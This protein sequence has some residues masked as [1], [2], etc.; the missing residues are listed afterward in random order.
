M[1]DELDPRPTPG[2]EVRRRLT[3]LFT[4][5]SDSTRLSGV[6]EAETYADMLDDVRQAFT[7]AVTARGGTINQFQGDGLQAL[8]GYPHINEHASRRATEAA[9]DIH[10]RVRALRRKYADQGASELS[11]HS[12]IHSGLMLA[13]QGDDV[14][15]RVELFGPAPGIAKHLSDEACSDEILVSED[16]LGPGHFLFQTGERREV[17]LKGREGSLGVYRV[18]ARGSLRTRFEAHA[19]RGLLPFIGRAAPLKMLQAALDDVTTGIPRFVAI[20]GAPGVGKT[21][22]AEE[23]LQ[24]ATESGCTVLRGW[25]EGELSAQPLQ[26]FLQMLRTLFQVPPGAV[27]AAQAVEQ[28][29]ARIDPLLQ[30]H[31]AELLAALSIATEAQDA[32]P[33]GAVTRRP[34]PEQTVL[35]LR[36]L[37][38]SLARSGPLVLFIDDW[39]WA[40]GATRQVVYAV[41]D[42]TQAPILLLAATR[43]LDPGDAQPDAA[44]TV[45]LGPFSDHEADRSIRAMLPAADPFVVGEIR[46]YAGGNPLFI[47]ELCHSAAIAGPR[48][49]PGAVPGG[50]AWLETLIESRVARLPPEQAE[51]LCAAAV[52]GNVVPVWLLTDLT[53]YG[54]EHP[55]LRGLAE[56][57]LVF[58]GERSGTLRFK[59]GITRDVVYAAIGLQK[60]RD[61]HRRIAHLFQRRAE[62]GAEAEICEALAYH[63]AGAAEFALAARHAEAAGD[64]AMAASSIDRA[65]AQ[66]RAALQMLERLPA[67]AERYQAWRSIVRRLGMASVFDPSRS[68]LELFQRAVALAREHGDDAGLAYAEYWLAYVNYALGESRAA[69]QHCELALAVATRLSDPRLVAQVR[70]TLGQALAAA[71]DYPTALSLLDETARLQRVRRPGTRPAPGVAYSL[72]CKASILG[73]QGRFDEADA[74]FDEALASLPS[75]GHE[76]EG[77]VLCWRSGILLWQGRWE[78]ARQAALEAQRV[79]ERVRSL[80]LL[81]TSRGMGAYA[82]WQLQGGGQALVDMAEAVSWLQ[83]R[84]KNLFASLQH[85]WLAEALVTEDRGDEARQHAAQ[86]LWR[87][88]KRDWIGAAAASRA[89]ARLAAQEDD[90]RAVQRHLARADRVAALRGSAHESAS[91]VLCR[92]LVALALGLHADAVMR[93]D[94]ACE[95]FARLGMQG[96]LEQALRLRTTL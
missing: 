4:D 3:I 53:G 39:H 48:P 31:R 55:L 33:K 12:G 38:S 87:T 65:K 71:A 47:E 29:L 74:C 13:R 88:R 52:I 58:P 21:R 64:K 82:S 15:G 5:L 83:R 72:A 24:R 26:P 20:S 56:Q 2:R 1:N 92:A 45:E 61:M 73:D 66:Y 23:F 54:E 10:E 90:M 30:L 22:L 68:E 96:P 62:P 59:H 27:A 17:L 32:F 80:Y 11:V 93:L 60:R 85:G 28:G 57:D 42:G 78:E 35:A 84:D 19:R 18:L 95:A 14:A 25:C 43:P 67:S 69:V 70:A 44:D 8:F 81:G 86:A 49:G 77:S 94:Q 76:V 50:S 36:H 9:L 37:F 89:M 63:H 34:A 16:T 91:N 7:A 75:S 41:R 6:M 46:H 51:V 40:D 79:A